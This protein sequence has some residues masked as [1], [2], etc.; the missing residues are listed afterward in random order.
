MT[1]QR[2]RDRLCARLEEMGIRSRQVLEVMRRVPRHI[3]L[4]EALASRA[5]ENTALPIGHGQTISQPYTV[6]RMTEAL[7][8][9]GPMGRVLEVGGG[10]G[11]QTVVLSRLCREVYTI[12]R[13][14]ELAG[15]LRRNLREL[16]VHNARV[17]H[18]DGFRGWPSAAPFDAILVAAAP[19]EVPEALL[20]QLG[21]GGRLVI[22]VGPHGE[23]RLLLIR[24]DENGFQE[25]EL[26]WV[27]FV[28][29]IQGRG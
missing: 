15:R 24:R 22:P 12:E 28:P 9:S 18:G 19:R 17:L 7:V 27:S 1:S 8:E 5:Y 14:R 10:C 20:E 4:D 13:L 6:A 23:Q 26:E 29:L 25:S 3:F 2:A 16:R 11:Y 21:P